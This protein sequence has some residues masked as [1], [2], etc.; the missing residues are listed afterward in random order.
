MCHIGMHCVDLSKDS[1]F[2]DETLLHSA[3]YNAMLIYD[4]A[5]PNQFHEFMMEKSK[6]L[7]F[8]NEKITV[9][10]NTDPEDDFEA[11]KNRLRLFADLFM[12]TYSDKIDDFSGDIGV[13]TG[14]QDIIAQEGLLDEGERFR[15]NC[16][17]CEYDKACVYRI[18][19]GP[20]EKTLKERF[21]S[22]RPI[23][24]FRKFL[25]IM[26]GMFQPKYIKLE[27]ELAYM[28]KR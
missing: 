13:F 8:P 17:E 4:Q 1:T 20:T 9:I 2:T 5:N 25:L 26:Q 3:L 16:V 7:T 18:T 12:K 14:F 15:K 27:M 11:Y 10:M 19:I 28:T 6:T 22:I 24:W 21:A 23:G